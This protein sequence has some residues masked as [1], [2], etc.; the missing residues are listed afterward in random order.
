MLLNMHFHRLCK[1]LVTLLVLTVIVDPSNKITGLKTPIFL[2]SFFFIFIFYLLN[3]SY[4]KKFDCSV[5]FSLSF[6]FFI[7][8]Y[9]FFIGKIGHQTYDHGFALYFSFVFVPYILLYFFI[10][11]GI[12]FEKIFIFCLKVFALMLFVFSLLIQLFYSKLSGVVDLLNYTFETA[13]IGYRDYGGVIFSMIYWKTSILIVFLSANL[14]HKKDVFS[15]LFFLLSIYLLFISGTRANI[16]VSVLFL[17]WW[18]NYRVKSYFSP[19]YYYGFLFLLTIL[20]SAV[21]LLFFD[22]FSS[23]FLSPSEKSNSV[24]IGHFF[25]YIDMFSSDLLSFLFGFGY[26]TAMFSNGTFGY[27]FTLELTYFELIRFYGFFVAFL[28]FAFLVYPLFILYK[29]RSSYFYAWL[30]YLMIAGSNP[31]LLSST[32]VF[33]LIFIY[34]VVSKLKEIDRQKRA[35]LC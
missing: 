20:I 10:V 8:L 3:R 4:L 2:V 17:F 22:D 6:L 24:K 31:L 1:F 21:T 15:T 32:G 33:S 9:G 13:M 18:L 7:S 27:L 34:F 25:S 11:L 23:T 16:F 5:L 30:T 28:F 14:F 19:C 29:H 35:K 12:D 26:G